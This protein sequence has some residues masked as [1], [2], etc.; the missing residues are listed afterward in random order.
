MGEVIMNMFKKNNKKLILILALLLLISI[1]I[2]VYSLAQPS[3]VT[4]KVDENISQMETNYEY[5]ATISPNMLYPEGGTIEVS[6]T[7]FKKITTAIP[8]D[9][10]SR[11]HSGKEVLVKGTYEVLLL[12]K[13]GDLW[14]KT[15]PLEQKQS[16]EHQSTKIAIIDKSF[17]IDMN[18][19]NSFITKVE[20]ETGVRSDQYSIEVSPNIQGTITYA[21]KEVP[22]KIEDKLIFQYSYDKIVLASEKSVSSVT[23]FTT[24]ETY[25]NTFQILGIVLP[26][27]TVQVFSSLLSFLLLVAI[28]AIGYK[29]FA[30]LRVK[31][32]TTQIEKI[33]KKYGSR[34]I[35]VSKKINMVN[36]S[37]FTL[38]SFKSVL[39]LSEDKELPIFFYRDSLEETGTYF[40]VDGDYLYTYETVKVDLVRNP[41]KDVGIG[42]AFAEN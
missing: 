38:Y 32:V 29:N 7:M 15:F 39:K 17:S 41:N 22:L 6:D 16:F 42:D 26:V 2:T 40:V 23:P 21:G 9:I 8:F 24:S 11:I 19:I 4:N 14:E 12:V 34:I 20:E 31:R 28:I 37:I 18:K 36:K 1:S 27:N 3:T 35:T 5:K 25:T 33:N 13:A 30:K 10:N